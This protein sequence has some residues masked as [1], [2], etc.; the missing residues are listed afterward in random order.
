ML[1]VKEKS[2]KKVLCEICNTEMYEKHCKIIC[3]IAA[4]SGI[5]VIIKGRFLKNKFFLYLP[6]WQNPAIAVVSNNFYIY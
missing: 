5:A 4:L 3:Q 1:N 2:D 6:R